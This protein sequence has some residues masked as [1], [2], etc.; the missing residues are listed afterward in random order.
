MVQIAIESTLGQLLMTI[1]GGS[2]SLSVL[3]YRLHYPL[4]VKSAKRP[5]E[6]GLGL[7]LA[8][9]DLLKFGIQIAVL[10]FLATTD[11]DSCVTL[12][13][14]ARNLISIDYSQC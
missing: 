3:D 10:Q 2:P 5:F 12:L 8:D 9:A 6:F 1:I 4:K 14:T 11:G 13:D 7:R